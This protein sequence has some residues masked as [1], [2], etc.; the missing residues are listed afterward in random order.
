MHVIPEDKTNVN[1]KHYMKEN[2]IGPEAL[3]EGESRWERGVTGAGMG[4][5]VDINLT[6]ISS[7]Q[8]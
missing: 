7:I 6:A 8:E 2:Q 5:S 3:Y 4:V 1:R